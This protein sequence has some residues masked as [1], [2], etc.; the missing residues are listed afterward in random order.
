MDRIRMRISSYQITRFQ[1]A[2]DRMIGDSQVRADEAN[3][4][5]LEL[6]DEQGRSGLGFV[7]TVQRHSHAQRDHSGFRSRGL[8]WTQGAVSHGAGPPGQPA[9]PWQPAAFY[10]SLP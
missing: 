4:A 5:S 1:F 6:I 10:H 3:I 7:S 9:A 8:A 2:R